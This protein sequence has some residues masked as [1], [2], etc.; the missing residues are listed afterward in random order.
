MKHDVGRPDGTV[1]VCRQRLIHILY[2]SEWPF[3]E[4]YDFRMV[5][6]GVGRE[7]YLFS[8]ESVFQFVHL[9]FPPVTTPN[10]IT[11]YFVI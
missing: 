7:E 3:A 11:E 8:A 10:K 4:L 9:V 6:M 1:P 2:V 5:E